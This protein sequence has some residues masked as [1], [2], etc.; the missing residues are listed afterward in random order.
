MRRPEHVCDERLLE[1]EPFCT[2]FLERD[3]TTQNRSRH[4]DDDWDQEVVEDLKS[5]PGALEAACAWLTIAFSSVEKEKPTLLAYE[6]TNADHRVFVHFYWLLREDIKHA[7]DA[8]AARNAV[9]ARRFLSQERSKRGL[10]S[11]PSPPAHSPSKRKASNE[12]PSSSEEEDTSAARAQLAGRT[13]GPSSFR[14]APLLSEGESSLTSLV[15]TDEDVPLSRDARDSLSTAPPRRHASNP[16]RLQRLMQR[17]TKFQESA[18]WGADWECESS[19]DEPLPVKRR[20]AKTKKPRKGAVPPARP[21]ERAPALPSIDAAPLLSDGESSLTSLAD[22]DADVHPLPRDAGDSLSTARPRRHASNPGRLQQLMQKETKLQESARRSADLEDESSADELLLV[23]RSRAKTKKLRKSA[24]PATQDSSDEIPLK[25]K[26][27]L[28]NRAKTNPVSVPTPGAPDVG[29]Q[30][31]SAIVALKKGR[32]K[33][34]K[35]SK[36]APVTHMQ[37]DEVTGRPALP[38]DDRPES[39][40]QPMLMLDSA[41]SMHDVDTAATTSE[42]PLAA[43]PVTGVPELSRSAPPRRPAHAQRKRLVKPR[44][45]RT[46]EVLDRS[47]K[48]ARLAQDVPDLG[49]TLAQICRAPSEPREEAMKAGYAQCATDDADSVEQTILR[50]PAVPVAEQAAGSEEMPNVSAT[51]PE[52]PSAVSAASS[53]RLKR[54]RARGMPETAEGASS[55]MQPAAAPARAERLVVKLPALAELRKRVPPPLVHPESGVDLPRP[56]T[57]SEAVSTTAAVSDWEGEGEEDVQFPPTDSDSDGEVPLSM[58]RMRREPQ[59][60]SGGGGFSPPSAAHVKWKEPVVEMPKAPLRFLPPIWASSRQEVCESFNWFRSY[61][62][63]VYFVKDIVRGYLLSAFSSSRDIFAQDGRLI[64][65]H[66]GGKAESLHSKEGR[67]ETQ[68]ASDQQAEDKSVRALLNTHRLGRPVVLLADD[69]Y[70]LFPYDLAAKGCTYIVLGYY[71]IAHA[72][73]ERHPAENSHGHVVRYK[74]AFHWCQQQGDPWWIQPAAPSGSDNATVGSYSQE[75]QH[76]TEPMPML[77]S[78]SE[79]YAPSEP[80]AAVPCSGDAL[81]LLA[82]LA[83]SQATFGCVAMDLSSPMA[84]MLID[85]T[86]HATEVPDPSKTKQRCRHCGRVWPLVYRQGW[87][88]LKPTCSAFW[89]LDQCPVPDE[90]GYDDS[91]L[92]LV[93]CDHDKLEDLRP[94]LPVKKV[95]KGVT[96]ARKFCKGWHCTK[97]GRLSSRYKWQYWE[98]ANCKAIYSVEEGRIRGYLELYVRPG[99]IWQQWINPDSGIQYLTPKSYE[100]PG[101]KNHYLQYILPCGRG[102]IIVVPGKNVINGPADKIL[103]DYQRQANSGELQFR[104]WPLRQHKCRGVLL[105]NYFSQNT[106][107]PYQYVGGTANTVSWDAA[108]SAVH[109]ARALIQQRMCQIGMAD[110][111]RFNEILSAAYMEKQKMAFHSDSEKGLGPVV[112]SL[113][114]GSPAYMH[115]RLLAKHDTLTGKGANRIALTLYLR[116]GDVLVMDGAGVQEYYEHTVLPL[117]FRIAATARWIEP[118]HGRSSYAPTASS[119]QI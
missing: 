56:A 23:Q 44:Q 65:S 54:K 33:K 47:A 53:V 13:S 84:N 93:P 102:R 4:G 26:V 91:F 32:G 114:L 12:R 116:H 8:Q 18:R 41:S 62:G 46:R 89:I 52:C 100:Y 67:A 10:W 118:G 113:S 1:D 77:S 60:T 87:M 71:H 69:K 82:S 49:G 16:G 19:A 30:S 112:A 88:C 20:R 7:R 75:L 104:R 15:D 80:L 109:D 28:S 3:Y 48:R 79:P 50:P 21:V 34:G 40:S 43:T 101:G 76:S 22:S 103:K 55:A 92:L 57:A 51:S 99:K 70:R 42:P 117:N 27:S 90:L 6:P 35:K 86:E 74:F 97:C 17:E 39:I 106:G 83:A 110:R 29:V 9:N 96:T 85:Q 61:Q 108:S 25:M 78:Q 66:G 11:P 24:V 98:C 14:A 64:I 73:A 105:T 38:Q 2:R 81:D 115:F 31:I 111:A 72:W 119:A 94:P 63:G 68:Q 5:H 45:P 58:L 107:E 95:L 37:K 59:V 36:K